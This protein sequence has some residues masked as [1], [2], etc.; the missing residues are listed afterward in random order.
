MKRFIKYWLLL[1]FFPYLIIPLNPETGGLFFAILSLFGFDIGLY[2]TGL[3]FTFDLTN[4]YLRTI[5]HWPIV[6]IL[7]WVLRL[8][9]CLLLIVASV[10]RNQS[11]TRLTGGA[12]LGL[13]IVQILIDFSQVKLNAI[14]FSDWVFLFALARETIPI[15][16]PSFSFELSESNREAVYG[17]VRSKFADEFPELTFITEDPP[18]SFSY[19]AD[20]GKGLISLASISQGTNAVGIVEG[21]GSD[22]YKWFFGAVVVSFLFAIGLRGSSLVYS[23]GGWIGRTWAA[24]HNANLEPGEWP[25][26]PNMNYVEMTG[27]TAIDRTSAF[28]LAFLLGL[29]ITLPSFWLS[30]KR[31]DKAK[32]LKN[33]QKTMGSK[34]FKTTKALQ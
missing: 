31:S 7:S 14:P 26:N 5:S 12:A 18:N 9:A 29:A 34:L 2:R 1:I 20:W 3:G 16:K 23:L 4:F 10:S 8:L 22:T 11:Q 13:L 30:A 32:K 33:M 28:V 27:N 19:Q 15:L 25:W 24:R 17:M 6:S 21:K